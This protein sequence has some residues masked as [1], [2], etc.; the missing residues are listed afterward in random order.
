IS[1]AF[2]GENTLVLVISMA[3]G[4]IIGE[5]IDIDKHFTKF[6]ERIG[7][8][9]Q[10]PGS[11]SRFADGFVTGTLMFCIG[12][13][14]IMGSFDAG[15]TGDNTTLYTKALLDGISAV[16]FASAMGIGVAFSAFCVLLYQG[17][18]VL[19]SQYISV[20]ISDYMV[21]E[22]TCAGSLLIMMIGI[23]MLDITNIKVM[24]ML[25]AVFM[26]FILCNFM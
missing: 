18:L 5:L 17:A 3:L 13:M 1:G 23:N 25:P 20:F 16:A 19:L 14:A 8:K 10:K 11:E 9:F 7:N 22:M 15:L 24:N 6:A 2:Q 21:A 12:A 4:T 26:P